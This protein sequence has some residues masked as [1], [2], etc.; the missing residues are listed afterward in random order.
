MTNVQKVND[1]YCIDSFKIRIPLSDLDYYSSSLTDS[2]FSLINSD[3]EVVD[4]IEKTRMLKVGD[5]GLSLKVGKVR[6]S[7]TDNVDCLQIASPSKILGSQ[8]FDG[9]NSDTF[10]IIHDFIVGSGLVKVSKDAL[11]N[12][13]MVT[14]FDIKR[15]TYFPSNLDFVKY[16]RH[17]KKSAKLSSDLGKGCK[18]YNNNKQGRGIQFNTRPTSTVSSPFLKLYDKLAHLSSVYYDFTDKNLSGFDIN[19]LVRSEATVKNKKHLQTVLGNDITNNLHTIVNLGQDELKMFVDHAKRIHI[20]QVTAYQTKK[21]DMTG[22]DLSMYRYIVLL[23]SLNKSFHQIQSLQ[24]GG[25]EK[26]D[27]QRTKRKMNELYQRYLSEQKTAKN[28]L[29]EGVPVW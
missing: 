19:G 22:N 3:A 14:D 10:S 2:K 16:C 17:L 8:Y 28:V 6:T 21:E 1:A 25:R 18:V 26:K 20:D 5:K 11:L 12:M 15:D 9:I 13:G 23:L 29:F 4:E 24:L 27:K 7:K